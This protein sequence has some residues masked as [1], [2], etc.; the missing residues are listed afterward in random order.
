MTIISK[1]CKPD[2][3]ESHNSLMLSFTN[4]WG[5]C[6][7]FVVCES[8]LESI[9]PDILALCETILDG[10]MDSG[11]FFMRDYLPLIQKDSSTC[12]SHSLCE[13]R[14]SFCMGLISRKLRRFLLIIFLHDQKVMMKTWIS[15]ER[16]ELL[17]W[18][19]KHT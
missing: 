7:S 8:F 19:K 16:K 12:R 17:R 3:F 1:A 2:N 14:T 11:N 15:W 5:L 6:S 10:S 18:N 13:G 4:V 9:S